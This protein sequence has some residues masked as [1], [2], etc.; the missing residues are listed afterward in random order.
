MDRQLEA[1]QTNAALCA[2]V[3]GVR[4]VAVGPAGFRV[5]AGDLAL[6]N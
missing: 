2:T 5:I 4:A 1:R 6:E 3:G